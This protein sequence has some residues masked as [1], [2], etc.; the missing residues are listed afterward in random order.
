MDASRRSR[1]F[2]AARCFIMAKKPKCPICR[3]EVELRT[4]NDHFP[5]CSKRCKLE[6]LGKWFNEEYSMP[7]TPDS[8]ERSLVPTESPDDDTDRN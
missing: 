8:T 6:D 5:F 3:T 1:P 2:L 4:T 7:M